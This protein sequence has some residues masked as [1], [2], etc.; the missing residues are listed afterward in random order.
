MKHK[1]AAYEPNAENNR[2]AA[3]N[4]TDNST[5]GMTEIRMKRPF[6]IGSVVNTKANNP[7]IPQ[8]RSLRLCEVGYKNR[9]K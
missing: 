8:R 9:V 4:M 6:L 3:G 7:L 1:N 2:N 5:N